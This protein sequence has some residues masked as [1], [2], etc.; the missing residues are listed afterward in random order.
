MPGEVCE[1]S[2]NITGL[3]F[4]VTDNTAPHVEYFESAATKPYGVFLF[5]E[6]EDY[7]SDVQ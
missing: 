7:T 3:P 5:G 2:I 6:V 1:G 4:T